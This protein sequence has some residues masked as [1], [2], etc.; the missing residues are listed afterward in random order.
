MKYKKGDKAKCISVTS[1]YSYKPVIGN[2]YT[3]VTDQGP[4]STSLILEWPN[5]LNEMD[6]Y[7]YDF[8]LVKNEYKGTLIESKV[9]I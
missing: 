1:S 8:E 2:I 9:L 6:F 7:P 5:I 3:V 4:G